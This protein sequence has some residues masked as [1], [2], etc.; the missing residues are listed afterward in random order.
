M[1]RHH[2]PVVPG[3]L[4]AVLGEDG[5][6]DFWSDDPVVNFLLQ[7]QDAAA[8]VAVQAWRALRS[9]SRASSVASLG[10]KQTVRSTPLA[11]AQSKLGAADVIITAAGALRITVPSPSEA[12]G[13]KRPS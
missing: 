4:V 13:Y 9:V 5:A 11:L 10:S 6:L 1:R 12:R 3:Q 7:R 2:A 8:I